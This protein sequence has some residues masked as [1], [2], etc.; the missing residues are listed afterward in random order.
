MDDIARLTEV[1]LPEAEALGF[2][3]VRVKI[4]GAEAGDGEPA[5]QVITPT[6]A[7]Q[8][9]EGTLLGTNCNAPPGV[10]A[11]SAACRAAS[12]SACCWRG[13]WRCSRR[14]C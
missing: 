12:A 2:E 9:P 13:R 11:R 10:A 7:Q 4:I 14:C 8:A 6:L 5:L 1:I 3:L